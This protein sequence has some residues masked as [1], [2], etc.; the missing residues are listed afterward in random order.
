L[1]QPLLRENTG[2]VGKRRV[3]H[4]TKSAKTA[5][6]KFP[7][8]RH[9]PTPYASEKLHISTLDAPP[10]ADGCGSSEFV[11]EVF[12]AILLQA[13][14]TAGQLPFRGGPLDGRK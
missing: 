9:S 5:V 4:Q 14:A 1:I 7:G 3:C 10:E 11:F 13:A 8:F 6:L 2:N 12:A